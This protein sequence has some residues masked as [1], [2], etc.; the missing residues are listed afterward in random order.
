MGEFMKED[1]QTPRISSIVLSGVYDGS[2]EQSEVSLVE[3]LFWR[4]SQDVGVEDLQQRQSQLIGLQRALRSTLTVFRRN[5][6]ALNDAI[7]D[8]AAPVDADNR[9]ESEPVGEPDSYFSFIEAELSAVMGELMEIGAAVNELNVLNHRVSTAVAAESMRVSLSEGRDYSPEIDDQDD[10]EEAEK[11]VQRQTVARLSLTKSELD[12]LEKSRTASA[13]I[14]TEE[15]APPPMRVVSNA[16]KQSDE[17][18]DSMHVWPDPEP[19]TLKRETAVSISSIAVPFVT[20]TGW[21]QMYSVLED[22]TKAGSDVSVLMAHIERGADVKVVVN[23]NYSFKASKVWV[24]DGVVFVQ[25]E[26]NV[27]MEDGSGKN[28]ELRSEVVNT[29]GERLVMGSNTNKLRCSVRF[30][31]KY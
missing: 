21:T 27:L 1:T 2:A 6:Q 20:S 4:A 25:S 22:G 28:Q 26:R 18:R 13:Q 10:N 17:I 30:F 3:N 24:T 19:H 11:A 9:V 15:P 16:V 8:S 7:T 14:A 31:A 12:L 29:C 23:G 5:S